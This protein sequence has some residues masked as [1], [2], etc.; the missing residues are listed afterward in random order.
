MGALHAEVEAVLNE[1]SADA[2]ARR[3]ESRFAAAGRVSAQQFNAAFEAEAARTNISADKIGQALQNRLSHYGR[4]SGV[5]FGSAF[6]SQLAQSMP[7][8]S[9]FAS[10]MSG[11]ESAAGKAGAV[12]GR[13]LGL[14]FTTAAAGLIGAAGYTLFKGFER[15]EVID[16]ARVQLEHLGMTG[17]QVQEI[18]TNLNR[19]VTGTPI[20]LADA[21]GSVS[22]AVSSGIKDI[23]LLTRYVQD[24]ADTAGASTGSFNEISLIFSQILAKGRLQGDE[25]RQLAQRSVN[26][27]AWLADNTHKSTA[28]IMKDISDGKISFED[29]AKAVESHAGGMAKALG[30]TVEGSVTNLQT[31]VARTGANF[32]SAIFGKP[33]EDSNDLAKSVTALSDRVNDL[34]NW[35]TAHQNDIKQFFAG[36]VETGREVADVVGEVSHAVGG[37]GNLVTIAGGAF[38]AWKVGGAINAVSELSGKVG[39]VNRGL[40]AMPGLAAMAAAAIVE[41]GLKLRDNSTWGN[42]EP[43]SP[44]PSPNDFDPRK[45]TSAEML[46]GPIVGPWID[47]ML[48]NTPPPAPGGPATLP[49]SP[50]GAGGPAGAQ[51]ERRGAPP[52]PGTGPAGEFPSSTASDDSGKKYA[53]QVPYPAGY[54]QPPGPGESLEQWHARMANLAAEH[55]L[56]EARA[57]LNQLESDV[58]ADANDVIAAQNHVV[59]AQMRAWEAERSFRDSQLQDVQAPYDPRYGGQPRPGQTAQQY[60]AESS[61]Y[62]AQQKRATA[63]A[64]LDRLQA[65]GTASTEAL[66]KAHN[67]LAKATNDE[68]QAALRL[69]DAYKSTSGQLDEIGAKLDADFGASKGLPGLAENLTKFL[70]NLAFAPVFG[71]MKAVQDANGGYDRD[72]QGSGLIGMLFSGSQQ[73]D[74]LPP[75]LAAQINQPGTAA[76]Y[77]GATTSSGQPYGLPAGTNTGGYGSSGAVFPSWVHALE[78]AFGV[79]ASTYPGH[80]ESDRNEPGYASNPQHLNR[81]IDWSGSPQAMQQFA[82]YLATI[83]QD[84][85]QVIWNGTGVGTGQTVE[86]AGGRSQPGYFAGDL[87]AHGN[88]VHTRQSAAIPLPGSPSGAPGVGPPGVPGGYQ[89]LG[90][91]PFGSIPIPLPVTIVG[92]AP[93]GGVPGGGGGAPGAPSGP[94]APSPGGGGLN[95]DALAAKESGGN[96]GINT[97]NGYFGGLQFDQST[98]NAY[99]PPGA[100]DRADL[101]TKE[102]QI[103]AAMAGIAA[104]GGPQS[105][106]PQNYGQLSL[107]AGITGGG[108]QGPIFGLSQG[109]GVGGAAGQGDF[110]S[111]FAPGGALSAMPSAGD[112]FG[113]IGQPWLPA[114]QQPGFMPGGGQP[115]PMGVGGAAGGGLLGARGVGGRAAPSQSVIGGRQFGQGLPASQGIGFNGGIIGAAAS[116][117]ASGAA[118]AASFGAGGGAASA[119]MDIGMQE[120]GRAIGAMG[121]YAGNAVGGVLETLALNDSPL[122]DPGKSWFGRLA[123]AAAGMRPALPNAAGMMG[124]EQNPNMAEGGKKKEP[125][126]PLTPD[127][128]K[129]G[130]GEAGQAAPNITNNFNATVNNPQTRD[131]DGSM[132]DVQRGLG[133]V[134]AARQPR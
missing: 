70:L 40:G 118:G 124:G 45:R 104:R 68:N 5:S 27:V 111:P 107:P 33:Q 83:P 76:A 120:I 75:D 117:A 61:F 8:I 25:V 57:R 98:W 13:A 85:E 74:T 94:G 35:V 24:M 96:W 114:P 116:M 87:A 77:P 44:L 37:L 26:V 34:G 18:Y 67:D 32:L 60:S 88:H 15:F 134:Q 101:A 130:Q 127:Q 56:A 112:Q 86:I 2:A 102:Q 105:L 14:A 119:A 89:Q 1:R 69:Q 16:K 81:G 12:A 106:W 95:W 48:G 79:K 133:A 115:S 82:D 51:R 100:P 110:G 113:N 63:Q 80:Q 97:G 17:Q 28:D 22:V 108:G 132:R 91:T 3:L 21:F 53:P 109:P 42:G 126:G 84:L 90:S 65:S 4:Q 131:M 55:D 128:A 6:G 7:G 10:A 39:D 31:A 59:D 36:A 58:N 129:A 73:R 43:V 52:L 93:G 41:L 38:I 54:G 64:Q 29:F 47:R 20:S 50:S 99:K 11:Y 19:V 103:Q 92:G 72:K 23:G 66:T 46:Y 122:A 123:I 71:A 121:Q 125:P 49:T 30:D 62:E 9:G 78:Q